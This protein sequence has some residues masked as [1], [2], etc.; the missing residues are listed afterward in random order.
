[1]NTEI[2]ISIIG[3]IGMFVSSFATWFF[4][5]RKY[6]TE[7]D[8]NTIRNMQDSLE[9]YTKLSDDNKERLEEIIASN[10]DLRNRNEKLELNNEKLENDIN[11]IRN[12]MFNLMGQI[13]LNM[14]CALRQR[15]IPMFNT[16][17]Q[18]NND[19]KPKKKIQ[20]R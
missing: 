13:C 2:I 9:F 20:G 10:A 5:R 1:M 17:P 7:V 14:Q 19:T 16:N 6:N 11:K 12:E 15:N 4:T 8:S 18:Y 3:I